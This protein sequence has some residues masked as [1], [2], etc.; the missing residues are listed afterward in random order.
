MA[1]AFSVMMTA[2]STIRPKSSAPR[3]I[4]LA[5]IWPCHMP[6]A[7]ISMDS[8]MT[9]AVISAARKLPSS[10]NSTAITSS[11]PSARLLVTVPMVASTSWVRSSTVVTSMPGGRDGAMARS[12]ASTAEETVRLL[13]PISISAVPTTT[14]R[15]F[16]LALPV[17]VSPPID[18]LG[19]VADP[20]RHAAAGRDDDGA[21][22]L[23]VLQTPAGAHHD[24]F[25]VAFDIACAAADIVGLDRLGHVGEGQA[26]RDQLRGVG[27]DL[28]LLEIAADRIHAGDAGHHLDLRLDDPVLHRAQIGV[29]LDLALQQLAVGGQE[30]AV[31]LQARHAVALDRGAGEVDGPHVDFA[32][33]GRDR[34]D[35]R[36]DALRQAGADLGQP[37]ADLLAREI[38]VGRLGED[39]RD[40][41]EAIARQRARALEARRAGQRRLDREGDLLLD[42]D[43]R[44]AP[45]RWC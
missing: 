17:R 19:E 4:R 13:A 28:V 24:A 16:S 25:A 7:V 34:A 2:P 31:A 8:G 45:A 29:L 18:T 41:R 26:E 23:D 3:L 38:D 36:L 15:P 40:L 22:F 14:S 44:Q 43:R 33:T 37:L 42:L 9:S 20:D 27:I 30:T 10:R 35:P 11:A 21:D 12:L 6:I 39:S 32:E 5:L 1:Q